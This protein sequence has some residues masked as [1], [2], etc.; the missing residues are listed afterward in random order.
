[1]KKWNHHMKCY[2]GDINVNTLKVGQWNSP[3]F[4]GKSSRGIEGLAHVDHYLL[5]Y[6]LYVLAISEANL[7]SNIGDYLINIEGYYILRPNGNTARL[8][9]YIKKNLHYNRLKDMGKIWLQYGLRSGRYRNKWTISCFYRVQVS[10]LTRIR[11]YHVAGCEIR[12]FPSD[13]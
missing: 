12:Q 8:I 1:M 5:K 4:L 3:S 11:Q 9:C 7:E 13:S 10:K 2:N 6:K